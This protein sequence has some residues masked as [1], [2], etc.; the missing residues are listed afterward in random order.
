M[1]IY[2]DKLV[3]DSNLWV[4]FVPNG[5][6]PVSSFNNTVAYVKN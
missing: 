1:Y 2:M 4:V 5:H 3:L 6:R